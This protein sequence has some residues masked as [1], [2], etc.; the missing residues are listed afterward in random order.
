[1]VYLYQR[2]ES[3]ERRDKVTVLYF[4]ATGNN[5][6]IAKQ[7]GGELISVPQAIKSGAACF[8]DT[9]IGLVFP[10]FE[11]A[12]PPLIETFLSSVSLECDYLFGVLSYGFMGG[13]AASHL[14]QIAKKVGLQF[15]YINTLKM[16]DNWVPG[17]EMA[18]QKAMDG[19]KQVDLHLKA[20]VN[21]IEARKEWICRDT[22][23][24]KLITRVMLPARKPGGSDF[25]RSFTVEDTCTRCGVCAKVCPV[26]NIAV[27]NAKPV[28]G[29][30]CIRCLACTHNCPANT[31][32]IPKEKSRERYRNEHIS[33]NEIIE[34]NVQ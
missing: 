29:A 9:K 11:V 8:K 15:S 3:L 19:K 27:D 26:K 17:F 14:Q 33:L 7:I 30:H 16:V 20:I 23:I 13:G 28:F 18:E 1:M 5:L 24:D 4:T 32:R 6:Y 25:A 12:V 21:D 22:L 10:I 34:A 2:R 31:I